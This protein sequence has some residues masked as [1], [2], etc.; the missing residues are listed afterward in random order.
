MS[1]ELIGIEETEFDEIAE[2]LALTQISM[3]I[4]SLV[5]RFGLTLSLQHDDQL[6]PMKTSFFRIGAIPYYFETPDYEDFA[7]ITNVYVRSTEPDTLFAFETFKSTACLSTKDLIWVRPQL[8]KASWLLCRTDD[9][10]NESVMFRF[11]EEVI[12]RAMQDIYTQRGHKQ[13]Y[14]VTYDA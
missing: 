4:E 13:M 1:S 9:N 11:N 2:P 3:P 6:G 14:W 5:Q 7:Q 8:G 12:A 10:G